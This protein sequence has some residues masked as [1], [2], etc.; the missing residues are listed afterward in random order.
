MKLVEL[1]PNFSEGKNLNVINKIAETVNSFENA[2]LLDIQKDSLHNRSVFTIVVPLENAAALATGLVKTASENISMEEH[3]GSHPRFG[4]TDVMPFIPLED[5]TMEECIELSQL[6]GKN[7]GEELKIPVY[8]YAMSALKAEREKL[9]DI[10]NMH[11]QYEDLKEHIGEEKYRPDYGP[12][13]VGT[14]GAVI[15]GA[16]DFLIAYN[17]YINTDNIITGRH[18][19]SAIRAKNGG[20]STVKS[21]AFKDGPSIQLSMNLTDYKRTPIYRVFEAVRMECR[22]YGIEPVRSE[23][24]GMVPAAAIVES[25]NYYLNSDLNIEKIVDLEYLK[26][27]KPS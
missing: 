12:S 21:L 24:I 9:E 6:V 17:I 13:V 4:A 25:L 18:I 3:R 22:R 27:L 7:V 5:T 16:R 26:K 10:R 11:F 15:I 8:M 23:F 19:A 20:Y 1:V 14:A 2:E